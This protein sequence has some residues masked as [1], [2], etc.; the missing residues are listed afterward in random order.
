MGRVRLSVV[1]LSGVVSLAALAGLLAGHLDGEA[2]SRAWVAS[3]VASL[4][5]A[6]VKLPGMG[7]GGS[8]VLLTAL[9]R[10]ALVLAASETVGAMVGAATGG[11]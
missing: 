4:L 9:T 5:A 6:D 8:A 10:G 1:V 2:A 7:G 3:L 11:H